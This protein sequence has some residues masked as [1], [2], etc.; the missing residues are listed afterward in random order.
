MNITKGK[1]QSA[2]KVVLYGPEGIGKSTFA[3]AFPDPL[4]IDTE[5]STK[6]LDV[7]RFDP[8]TSW[9]MMLEQVR[10]AAQ[11]G[12]CKTLVL[13]TADW[14]EQM[15]VEAV[16]ARSSGVKGLEDFGYGKGYTYLQEEFG[17]LLN[18]LSD[19]VDKG[20]HVVLTAHATMRKQELPDELGAFDRW[21]LKLSKKVAPMVKEWADMVLFANYKTLVINVDNQGAAKGKNKAQGG[22]RVMYTSH[23]PTWDAKNR[24]GLQDELPLEYTAIA[25]CFTDPLAALAQRSAE[26]QQQAP[27][28]APA[29]H[30]PPPAQP[31]ADFEEIPTDGTPA[32]APPPPA[33]E[34]PMKAIH[35]KLAQLMQ[36]SGV[37]EF[38]IQ[39]AVGFRGYFPENTPMADYPEDF[40]LGCLV[41]D[42]AK[43]LGLIESRKSDLPF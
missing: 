4:F 31:Q 23:R 27:A 10:Y 26:L 33:T 15:C 34:P 43:V 8:P 7:R 22:Q 5:G 32:P 6:H 20:V 1:I 24:H 11:P 14:A 28:A 36:G 39:D 41:A 18:A 3:A 38:E 19:V 29:V 9:A 25:H 13:D 2:Q 12:V 37:S 17:R 30:P 42:W 21:E 16:C 35:P 40:V